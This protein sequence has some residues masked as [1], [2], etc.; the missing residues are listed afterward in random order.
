MRAE[1]EARAAASLPCGALLEF[2][3]VR[4]RATRS[5]LRA[6]RAPCA[7]LSLCAPCVCVVAQEGVIEA[8][9]AQME[10]RDAAAAALYAEL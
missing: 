6:R 9:L 7:L 2:S 5:A 4:D 8:H 3:D 10:E 1:E